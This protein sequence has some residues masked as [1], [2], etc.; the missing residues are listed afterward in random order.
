MFNS[1]L[2]VYQRVV[3]VTANPV[4]PTTPPS[5]TYFGGL[6]MLEWLGCYQASTME[7]YT[8]VG[9]GDTPTNCLLVPNSFSHV[10]PMFS[11]ARLG[12]IN[13]FFSRWTNTSKKNRR[14]HLT[15]ISRWLV[16]G[17]QCQIH[18]G[19]ICMFSPF[20]GLRWGGV[21]GCINVRR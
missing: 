1:F 13:P 9:T 11:I 17:P 8:W 10:F 7:F 4:T 2:L 16:V 6:G 19:K 18:R 21:G 3:S 15:D 12:V 5:H 14:T 20:E